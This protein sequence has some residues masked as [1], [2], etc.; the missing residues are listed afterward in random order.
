MTNEKMISWV[1]EFDDTGFEQTIDH[2]QIYLVKISNK[3]S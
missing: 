3:S 1:M 2:A